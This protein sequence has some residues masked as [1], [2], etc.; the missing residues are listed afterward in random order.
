MKKNLF[1]GPFPTASTTLY[2][3]PASHVTTLFGGRMRNTHASTTANVELKVVEVQTSDEV[4]LVPSAFQL[5]PKHLW[6]FKEKII[7]GAGDR[8]VGN[9]DQV[10]GLKLDGEEEN[11]A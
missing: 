3:V 11:L 8:I 6:V 10:V 2:T 5:K 4:G 7:L 1:T 9:A